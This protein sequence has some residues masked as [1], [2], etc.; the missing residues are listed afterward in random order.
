MFSLEYQVQEWGLRWDWDYIYK[1]NDVY[2]YL[3]VKITDKYHKST[4]LSFS[5]DFKISWITDKYIELEWDY[6]DLSGTF[7]RLDLPLKF[8]DDNNNNGWCFN[9]LSHHPSLTKEMIYKYPK[10]E[11]CAITV[12]ERFDFENN[13]KIKINRLDKSYIID[14]PSIYPL[15]YII[16]NKDYFPIINKYS[17]TIFLPNQTESISDETIC[18][19]IE[20]DIFIL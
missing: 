5:P 15:Y 14:V 6:I 13:K 8:I 11:W 12:F 1:S 4:I 2:N 3:N 10:K 7:V 16:Y 9:I 18:E 20:Y 19:E 17:Y